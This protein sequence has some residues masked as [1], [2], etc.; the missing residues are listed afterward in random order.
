MAIERR[1]RRK[2]DEESED[3]RR[4]YR[5]QYLEA[6]PSG[7]IAASAAGLKRTVGLLA[8]WTTCWVPSKRSL[9]RAC[10]ALSVAPGLRSDNPLGG[11][12]PTGGEPDAGEPPVRFG[13][14]GPS[15]SVLPTLVYEYLL[16]EFVS[17]S[18]RSSA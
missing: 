3:R 1:E 11:E 10:R 18:I 4:R 8:M 5:S 14:R 17:P 15:K 12:P 16:C 6:Y 7:G 9:D 2:V 13:G